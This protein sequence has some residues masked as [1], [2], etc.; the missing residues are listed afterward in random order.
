MDLIGDLK[1]TVKVDD[2][3]IFSQ[4]RSIPGV[5]KIHGLPGSNCLRYATTEVTLIFAAY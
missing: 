1:R 5:G 3:N 2:A 4:L